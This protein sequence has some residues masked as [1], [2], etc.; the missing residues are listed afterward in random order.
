[1]A[2]LSAKEIF[3]Q[4]I[5]AINGHDVAALAALMAPK[6][7]FVDALGNRVEGARSMQSGWRGYF[8]MCPDYWI[9]VDHR[10]AEGDTLLS[11]GEAGGTIDGESWRIPAA[12]KAVIRDG[13]V[14]EWRVYAD[15]KPVYEILGRRRP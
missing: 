8:A 2:T 4:W 13:S 7:V 6:H 5:A 11:T 3:N 1:M 15:N 12:W 14:A 9:R 10:M